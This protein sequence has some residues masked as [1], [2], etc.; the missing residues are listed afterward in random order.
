M[1]GYECMKN[2]RNTLNSVTYRAQRG[3][4]LLSSQVYL[5]VMHD[6]CQREQLNN[7]LFSKISPNI[8]NNYFCGLRYKR[9][10]KKDL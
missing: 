2:N 1:K 4:S 5:F 3:E 9:E 7:N 8:L 10:A 6:N